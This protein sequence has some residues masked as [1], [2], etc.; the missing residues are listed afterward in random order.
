[1][2]IVLFIG[3]VGAACGE[4]GFF[5]RKVRSHSDSWNESSG[6]A[7]VS[8]EGDLFA[9][10]YYLGLCGS[11]LADRDGSHI[12]RYEAHTCGVSSSYNSQFDYILKEVVLDILQ[13]RQLI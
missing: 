11:F 13:A 7:Y 10:S 12:F 1:M 3:S 6:D 9:S 2:M 5:W 4:A 8:V